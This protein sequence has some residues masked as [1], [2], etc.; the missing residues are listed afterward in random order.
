MWN[1]REPPTEV[2]CLQMAV[3]PAGASEARGLQSAT[4]AGVMHDK[5]SNP[6][7]GQ[8]LET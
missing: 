5:G 3:M 1:E 8:L 6:R 7:I 2:Y 4:L